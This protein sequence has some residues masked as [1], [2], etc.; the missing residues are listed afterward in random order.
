MPPDLSDTMPTALEPV[1]YFLKDYVGDEY[2]SPLRIAF[3]A[4]FALVAVVYLGCRGRRRDS[5][6]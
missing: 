1:V 5:G 4:A 3:I 2:L 6:E